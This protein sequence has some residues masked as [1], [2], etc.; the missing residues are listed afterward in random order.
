MGEKAKINASC[1]GREDNTDQQ[2]LAFL[3]RV[4]VSAGR[5]VKWVPECRVMA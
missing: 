4:G 5:G 2:Q 3:A 1:E